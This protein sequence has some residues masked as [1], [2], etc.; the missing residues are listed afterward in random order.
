MHIHWDETLDA[1]ENQHR[2]S[3]DIRI[4]ARILIIYFVIPEANL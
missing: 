4:L 2:G 1:V 3:L